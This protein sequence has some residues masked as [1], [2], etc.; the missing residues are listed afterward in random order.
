MVLFR[1]DVHAFPAVL[2]RGR[3]HSHVDV[4]DP[5]YH[6]VPIRPSLCHDVPGGNCELVLDVPIGRRYSRVLG[7]MEFAL[8]TPLG[9]YVYIDSP[10][11]TFD[12][13]W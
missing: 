3:Q 5:D 8:S 10:P 1:G 12:T 9:L 6:E 13:P 7:S 4:H 11:Q 2:P